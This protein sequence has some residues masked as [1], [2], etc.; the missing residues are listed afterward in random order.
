MP[1]EAQAMVAEMD[2]ALEV[3]EYLDL[4]QIWLR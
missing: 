3:T 1:E 2:S 4:K